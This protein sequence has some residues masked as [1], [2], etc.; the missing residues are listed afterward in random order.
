M[1][2]RVRKAVAGDAQA[3]ARIHVETWRA[4]YAGV[5]PDAY[6]VQMDLARQFR[7]WRHTIRRSGG[8]YHVL[9]A[10]TGDGGVIGFAS[11]G[12]A[13]R[14]G[15][16]RRTHYD[17]EIYTLYVALD[18]QGQ[19]HGRA[20]LD[21]CLK[22][23][24]SDGRSAAVVWVL[25]ANPARFFYEAMGGERVAERTEKFA[26]AELEELAFGWDLTAENVSAAR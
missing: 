15:L 5:I 11:C 18:H 8:S 13:R 25:A 4:T 2:G 19:G 16:P 26:G 17:G 24:R 10:E 14:A 23:L 3:V 9:V 12:A 7:M 20:L 1:S 21:A 22:R 6:L